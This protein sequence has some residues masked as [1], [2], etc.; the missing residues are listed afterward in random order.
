M[1]SI[2]DAET[3]DFDAIQAIYAQAVLEGTASF[4]QSP[5]STQDLLE[6][7][8]TARQKGLP[9]LVALGPDR[10]V[11][12]AYALPYRPRVSYQYTI[13][14]SVYVCPECQGRGVGSALM[15]ELLARCESGPWHQMIAIIG[16]SANAGSIALHRRH[17][18]QYVGTLKNVGRKFD[19]W[20]DSVIMQRALK[21][22]E[23]EP[24]ASAPGYDPS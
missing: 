17:G 15:S 7:L 9:Y 23:A 4:E 14:N 3:S 16:D 12:Y 6:R 2:R 10:L 13:E 22:D 20:L 8:K 19:R 21:P 5:P 1:I 24:N 18:F 11:G